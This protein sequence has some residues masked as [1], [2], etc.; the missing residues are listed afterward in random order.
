L[1]FPLIGCQLPRGRHVCL[2]AGT[3][4]ARPTASRLI[5]K[6]NRR[7]RAADRSPHAKPR[8]AERAHALQHGQWEMSLPPF[9]RSGS[10][11]A[12]GPATGRERGNV[13]ADGRGD[14]W[15]RS[16]TGRKSPRLPE[17]GYAATSRPVAESTGD[18]PI[19]AVP[20]IT[21]T[22]GY[23]GFRALENIART[24]KIRH[25]KGLPKLGVS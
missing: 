14:A 18:M 11:W 6:Q 13:V 20:A 10:G 16:R 21:G 9:R 17:V 1:W 12:T 8:L 2:V 15:S 25:P 7:W 23:V 4:S 22:M 3:G 24:K 19:S 5:S